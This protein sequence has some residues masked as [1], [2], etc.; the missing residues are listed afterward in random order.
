MTWRYHTENCIR[1]WRWYAHPG[2][3]EHVVLA[4]GLGCAAIGPMPWLAAAPAYAPP[5]AAAPLGGLYEGGYGGYGGGSGGYGF[6]AFGGSGGAGF[7]GYGGGVGFG[8]GAGGGVPPIIVSGPS[9]GPA[10]GPTPG[11]PGTPGGD[12]PSGGGT[13]GNETPTPVPEPAPWIVLT[14]AIGMLACVRKRL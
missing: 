12:T 13:P 8:P 2:I 6:G 11:S 5:I 7:E 4:A 1:V 3:A 14:I 10:N 9:G